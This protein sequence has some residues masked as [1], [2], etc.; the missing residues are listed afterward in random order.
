[1]P[2]ISYKKGNQVIE[3]KLVSDDNTVGRSDECTIKIDT[4]TEV[5]RI[6]CSIQQYSDGSYWLIDTASKNGTFLNGTR[7]LNDEA[8]LG[9]GDVIRVGMTKLLFSESSRYD[10]T[11]AFKEAEKE[12]AEG[13]DVNQALREITRSRQRAKGKKSPG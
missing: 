2:Y 9:S 1:M 10:T 5:S 13:K 3:K 7:L 11:A 8:K 4:D 12:I 6:H